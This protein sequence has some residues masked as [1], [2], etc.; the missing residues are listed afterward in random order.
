MIQIIKISKITDDGF[1]YELYKKKQFISFKYIEKFHFKKDELYIDDELE[2]HYYNNNKIKI[3][4]PFNTLERGECSKQLNFSTINFPDNYLINKILG[5][6]NQSIKEIIGNTKVKINLKE[7]DNTLT[8]KLDGF[9][10]TDLINIEHKLFNLIECD[11]NEEVINLENDNKNS[12]YIFSKI[13]KNIKKLKEGKNIRIYVF[14]KE[15]IP[16]LLIYSKKKEDKNKTLDEILDLLYNSN[17]VQLDD[18]CDKKRIGVI[19][20][21][22]I[23]KGGDTIKSLNK[24]FNANIKLFEKDN[25]PYA[26][27]NTKEE[28]FDEIHSEILDIIYTH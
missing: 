26:S 25:I 11:F 24:K 28:N 2:I 5:Y 10:E 19:M 23:G 18:E 8:I 20:I 12:K 21:K 15:N 1:I 16:K 13:I 3:I 27:I 6:K 7:K 22:V 9:N 4:K 17:I 14:E